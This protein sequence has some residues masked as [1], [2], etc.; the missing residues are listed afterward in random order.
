MK[1]CKKIKLSLAI[2]TG[3][4]HILSQEELKSLQEL[5]LEMYKDVA[6][7]CDK[8]GLEYMLAYGSCIGAVRHQG[9]IPWDD[10]LDI[11]MPMASYEQLI[12]LC[13]KGELGDKYEI[14]VP[15]RDKDNFITFLKIY[16]RGTTFIELTNINTP[17]LKNICIDIF[18]MDFAP[19][20]RIFR[21]LKGLISNCMRFICTCVL[22][23]QYPSEEERKLKSYSFIT[24][25]RYKLAY[26][27]GK[28]FGII[29][30]Q[31]WIW[32]FDRFNFCTRNTGFMTISIGRRSYYKE[33]HPVEC[34]LPTKKA[35]FEGIEVNIPSDADIYLTAAYGD[36]MRIPPIEEREKHFIYKFDIGEK[37]EVQNE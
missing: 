4:C 1:N 10:D 3:I 2:K 30:H 8:Y 11:M 28:I 16:R 24:K 21:V 20:N 32:W 17:F 27:V 9:F 14:G 33:V 13:D 23:S 31:K 34:F 12:T 6:S 29:K 15:R 37:K 18:T 22:Y 26:T 25:I 36:Y 7:L 5:L 35:I 19:K